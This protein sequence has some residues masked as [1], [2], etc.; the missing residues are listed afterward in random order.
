ME[1]CFFLIDFLVETEDDAIDV[2]DDDDEDPGQGNED[3]DVDEDNE[4]GDDFKTMD[5]GKN[6]GTNSRMETEPSIPPAG[7]SGA[8]S[9][10][11]QNLESF[12]QGKVYGKEPCVLDN[13][14]LVLRNAEENIGKNLL[15][16]FD[17]ESDEEA[18]VATHKG[19][20]L[21]NNNSTHV[22]PPVAWKEKKQW[23]PVQATRMNSRIPRDGK[24][25]IEKAQDLKKAK[26]LEIPKANQRRR[27]KQICQLQ[28][29]EGMVDDNK[30]DVET[31][32][33]QLCSMENPAE[34]RRKRRTDVHAE[35]AGGSGPDATNAVVAGAWVTPQ[36]RARA[37][38]EV[39]D[40]NCSRGFGPM[41]ITAE[42]LARTLEANDL[43]LV[44]DG[45]G[46]QVLDRQ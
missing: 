16:H 6:D 13:N 33:L 43:I 8:N 24:T 23:G 12:V 34:R 22:K 3:D 17:E 5:K 32:G 41:L 45:A 44:G 35:Q 25:V 37:T 2:E 9:A 21:M 7:R 36:K 29:D 26:N 20:E 30:G 15:Q 1:Q 40:M 4:I 42:D 19:V 31:L 38:L 14:A 18:E 11:Q 39:S 10:V 28:G 27:K 46:F